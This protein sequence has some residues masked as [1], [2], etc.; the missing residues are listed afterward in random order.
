VEAGEPVEVVGARV[1]AEADVA[2]EVANRSPL[3]I[4][5]AT[6]KVTF[7]R[8]RVRP[9]PFFVPFHKVRLNDIAGAQMARVPQC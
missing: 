4:S 2:A 1:V 6:W 3:R 5:I 8:R 9:S 7:S